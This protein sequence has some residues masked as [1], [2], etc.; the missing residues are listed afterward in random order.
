MKTTWPKLPKAFK[1]K[2]VAALRSGKFEQ[3]QC[4]LR[5]GKQYCCLGVACA[6]GGKQ[7]KNNDCGYILATSLKKVTPSVIHG[8]VDN[9]LVKNLQILM[10]I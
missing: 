9:A 2:W 7:P 8:N 10:M 5:D 4:T 6:V 3:G 1:K